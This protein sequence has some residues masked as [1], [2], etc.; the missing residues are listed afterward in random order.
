MK[1]N[2]FNKIVCSL[3]FISI[4]FASVVALTFFVRPKVNTKAAGYK[5]ASAMQ[6][7]AEEKDTIDVLVLGD[8]LAYRSI[9]PLRIW[10]SS[11][12][13]SYV[14]G[15]PS[16]R[17]YYSEEFLRL[18]FEKQN[19]KVVMIE[20][21][22]IFRDTDVSQILTNELEKSLGFF[23]FHNRWK[24]LTKADITSALSVNYS[25]KSDMKG[26]R[27]S[28]KAKKADTTGYMAYTT[29]V[30]PIDI[31]NEKLIEKLSRLCRKNG[32]KL[33]LYSA[34]SVENYDY[35][36]HNALTDL[37]EKLG[38]EYID[39]NL[40]RNEIP[41]NWKY[42]ST[43]GGDH[44]NY[45]GT[46]KVSDYV[47][48]YLSEL[49]LFEDKRLNPNYSEWNA[50]LEKFNEEHKIKSDEKEAHRAKKK[51]A[52]NLRKQLEKE[53]EKLRNATGNP[54]A[55]LPPD[56]MSELAQLT[57]TTAVTRASGSL[58]AE[59]TSQAKTTADGETETTAVK[60]KNSKKKKSNK[61]NGS[62]KKQSTAKKTK[63]TEKTK[64]SK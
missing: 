29:D 28:R 41:I 50:A 37:A 32:A 58:S 57:E 13:T 15:T 23:R 16:Q 4:I 43:D 64:K 10:Q 36:R 47:A 40:M 63:K 55:V 31:I 9:S 14:C 59:S 25:C 33:V 20:T 7:A 60:K 46:I 6:I 34:P 62:A 39:M 5:H 24:T 18:A 54:N 27:F 2:I 44:L 42:S 51:A 49:K 22:A 8:S 26:Y 21:N 56:L 17:L 3:L 38:C 61:K 52:K 30:E 12:I 45:V 53:Q 11:G 1:K 35:A 48:K 19:P